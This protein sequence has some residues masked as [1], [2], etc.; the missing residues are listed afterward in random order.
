MSD[1]IHASTKHYDP[2]SGAK[3]DNPWAANVPKQHG[4][5]VLG[6]AKVTERIDSLRIPKPDTQDAKSS[7]CMVSL[8][9]GVAGAGT[10]F[11]TAATPL[12]FGNSLHRVVHWLR[13]AF[14]G[15]VL[16]SN[17]LLLHEKRCSVVCADAEYSFCCEVGQFCTTSKGIPVCT[18]STPE[19]AIVCADAEYSFCCEVGQFCTTSNGIPVCTAS[20]SSGYQAF[21]STTSTSTDVNP[22]SSSQTKPLSSATTSSTLTPTMATSTTSAFPTQLPTHQSSSTASNTQPSTTTSSLSSSSILSS[23]VT[24][25]SSSSSKGSITPTPTPT[26]T[27]TLESG[28]HHFDANL[29]VAIIV[30]I[31]IAVITIITAVYVKRTRRLMNRYIFCCLKCDE[32]GEEDHE[33]EREAHQ[34]R[35]LPNSRI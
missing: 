35:N 6:G 9:S 33:H 29:F 3:S 21:P 4:N 17:Q 26:P 28:G 19:C 12:P 10:I 16:Q 13:A 7:D 5:S 18:A 24:S 30:P 1:G 11:E 2:T 14:C 8:S 27:P 23:S 31:I 22:I 15:K 20:T 34:M 32:E 25:S